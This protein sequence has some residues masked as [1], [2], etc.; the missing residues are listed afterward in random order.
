MVNLR[1]LDIKGSCLGCLQCGYDNRCVYQDKDGYIEFYNTRVKTADIL[2]FAGAIQDRY[3]SSTWKTFFD[4]SFFNTHTPTLIGKQ[5]AFLIS[6]PLGQIPNLR[7]ILDG[8]VQ[9]QQSNLAGFVSDEPGDANAVDALLQNLAQTVI[10]NA[11]SGYI[12][13]QTFLGV[14]GIKIFRDDIWGRL[15][16]VFQADHRA[17]KQLGIYDFPQ[18]NLG[19]R[20]LNAATGIL[21]KV[22]RFRAEFARRIKS[23][24]VR[25]Y[26]KVLQQ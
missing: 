13:P 15:R 17:Y 16:T 10:R 12:A 11:D 14:G 23:Q 20:V 5:F 25:P 26:Q 18:N 2:V 7:H 21:F 1:D 9:L 22:P 19:I 3:L 8:W 24:M 6:G 4:R